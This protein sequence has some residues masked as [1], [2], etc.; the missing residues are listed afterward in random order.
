MKVALALALAISLPV[1][2]LAQPIDSTPIDG[3]AHAPAGAK[4]IPLY[5]KETPGKPSDEAEMRFFGRE[6]VLRNVT[7]PTLTPVFPAPGKAN[8]TAVIVAPGGGFSILAMQN[9]GWRVAQALADRG[10]TAFVLKY[11]LNP[12]PR[13]DQ[14]FMAEMAKMFAE[15]GRAPG[16]RPDLKNPDATKDALAALKMI[17]SRAGDWKVDPA[18]V[19]MIGFSAGAMTTLN[20]ILESDAQNRGPDFIGFIYGPMTAIE[21]PA[22]APP[23]FAAL[24]IDDPLFGNGDFSIVSAWHAAKRPVELHVYQAGGHGFGTGRPGTTSTMLMPEFLAWM[25]AQG[26]LRPSH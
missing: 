22:T 16:R 12:T 4:E 10:V 11:R 25:D 9:E 18:R 5:G 21:V 19:A 3:P 1:A 23:M 24:A 26:L 2:A 13:D 20:A 8:G 14:A 7:Y 17:R 6:T 15:V